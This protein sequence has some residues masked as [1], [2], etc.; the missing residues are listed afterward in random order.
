MLNR[1]IDQELLGKRAANVTDAVFRDLVDKKLNF[2]EVSKSS[3]LILRNLL[4]QIQDFLVKA[5]PDWLSSS[6]SRCAQP[7]LVA[8]TDGNKRLNGGCSFSCLSEM[9]EG[10]K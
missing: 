9:A 1:V 2:F 7:C 5:Y 6:A 4:K 8:L 10:V 3:F